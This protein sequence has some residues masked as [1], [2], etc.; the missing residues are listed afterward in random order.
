[1]DR[2]LIFVNGER[3]ILEALKREFTPWAA[4]RGIELAYAPD[5]EEAIKVLVVSAPRFAVVVAGY[6]APAMDGAGLAKKI[7][8]R[9]PE[10]RCLILPD[11]A[12]GKEPSEGKP[13]WDAREL[14]E[15]VERAFCSAGPARDRASPV[16]SMKAKGFEAKTVSDGYEPP[17][18]TIA[19]SGSVDNEVASVLL[20]KFELF[21]DE[22]PCIARIILDAS[23]LTYLSSTGAG[24]FATMAM[25]SRAK[26]AS[27]KVAG[28]AGNPASV[29]SLLG[30]DSFLGEG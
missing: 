21:M 15:A 9:W 29:L 23:G 18:L 14:R 22:T 28:A 17:C 4:S 6:R 13:T 20:N 30:F 16:F 8:A 24:A 7:S 1:M 26:K 5:E 19:L 11:R 12:M 10:Y 27:F 25:I 3:D 2:L